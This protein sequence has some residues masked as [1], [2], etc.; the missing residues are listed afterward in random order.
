MPSMRTRSGASLFMA[1]GRTLSGLGHGGA[2]DF[3]GLFAPE[4]E[5]HKA[6]HLGGE[7]TARRGAA[8]TRTG[9]FACSALRTLFSR[10]MVRG[11]ASAVKVRCRGAVSPDLQVT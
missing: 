4:D 9:A 8:G 2:G 3:I 7:A 10:M 11:S 1:A 6:L 5:R